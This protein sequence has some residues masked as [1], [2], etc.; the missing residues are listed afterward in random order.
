MNL[1]LLFVL[2][3]PSFA[4]TTPPPVADEPLAL[5]AIVYPAE[6]KQARIQGRVGLRVTVDATGRVTQV[7]ALDGPVPLRQA[8]VDAYMGASY[9]PLV[10]PKS[11]RPAPA[12]ITTSVEFNLHE[13]P[14][15]TDQK[16]DAQFEPLHARC[17]DEAREH[18]ATALA[19]C[20]EAVEMSHRFTP[21]AQLEARATAVNDLVLV[22]LDQKS[23]AEAASVADEAVTL[24]MATNH[25]HTPAVATA[26]IT[27]CEARSLARDYPGAAQDCAVAEETL[28]TLL[29]DQSA[30]DEQKNDRTANYK[31]QL[32]ETYELHAIVLDK[33]HHPIEAK[34]LRNKARLV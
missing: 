24:V 17:E 20:R 15:D 10:D 7:E 5:P 34:H 19:T 11:G 28:T 33:S 18:A 26:Y 6:A 1:F 3:L 32:R 27:R 21:L 2:I 30:P 13:L 14:P 25:P 23:Y 4:Q 22:L 31:T 16:V 8:A 29:A 12:V 9:R